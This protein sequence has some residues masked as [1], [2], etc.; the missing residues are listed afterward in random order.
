MLTDMMLVDNEDLSLTPTT[1]GM[2]PFLSSSNAM[3]CS[4]PLPHHPL[5]LLV[6]IIDEDQH[7]LLL[8]FIIIHNSPATPHHLSY[9]IIA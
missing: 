8:M 2:C 4:I 6:I 3:S 7:L 5:A 9:I 1:D